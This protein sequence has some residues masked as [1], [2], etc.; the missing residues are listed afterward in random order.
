MSMRVVLEV[1]LI[2]AAFFAGR[3]WQ[4]VRDA[5]GRMNLDKRR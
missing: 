4:F 3:L 1:G 2:V 5:R